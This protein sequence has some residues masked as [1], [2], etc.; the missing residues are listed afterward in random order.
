MPRRSSLFQ[1]FKLWEGTCKE[2][3]KQA[4]TKTRRVI[5]IWQDPGLDQSQQKCRVFFK[6]KFQSAAIFSAS[7]YSSPCDRVEKSFIISLPNRLI[8]SGLCNR[9]E[10]SPGWESYS[11]LSVQ[12][13]PRFQS[14][15]WTIVCKW[16]P[17]CAYVTDVRQEIHG[18]PHK[19]S[20]LVSEES[21]KIWPSE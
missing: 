17:V 20:L 14:N 21:F 7:A 9:L 1:P 8:C 4:K 6:P 2:R 15:A 3:G 16:R 10:T 5:A 19:Q 18:R 13:L 12:S 11:G